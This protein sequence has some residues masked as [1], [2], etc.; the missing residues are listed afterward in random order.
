MSLALAGIPGTLIMSTQDARAQTVDNADEGLK[1]LVLATNR[2]ATMEEE[3]NAA[4]ARGCRFVTTQGG[5]TA[6]GG[7]E[8]VVVMRPD[9]DGRRYRYV[10]LAT[11]RTSTMERELNETDPAFEIVGATFPSMFGGHEA[12]AILE[13]PAIEH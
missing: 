3:L 6:F 11:W 7:S 9:D 13:A 8:A 12:A 4:G 2:T 10:L 1:F 5:E